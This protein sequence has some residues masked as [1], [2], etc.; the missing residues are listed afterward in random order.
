MLSNSSILEYSMRGIKKLI[1]NLDTLQI[2]ESGQRNG[3]YYKNI[4]AKN[5][6]FWNKPGGQVWRHDISII[7]L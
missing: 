2:S 7:K 3:N 6:T 5:S 4:F 1:M